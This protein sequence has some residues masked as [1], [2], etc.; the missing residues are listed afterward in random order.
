MKTRTATPVAPP[1]VDDDIKTSLKLP[2][3]LWRG[4]KIRAADER[5][6]LRAIII[7]ALTAYLATPARS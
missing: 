3:A 2:P 7:R 1:K 6:N 4:A 5:T